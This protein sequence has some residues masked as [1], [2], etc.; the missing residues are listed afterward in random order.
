MT[1]R[2]MALCL[3]IPTSLA[4]CGPAKTP[5]TVEYY[6]QHRTEMTSVLKQ[7]GNNPGQLNADPDCVNASAAAIASQGKGPS[8][9]KY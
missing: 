2:I 8:R 6:M 5:K 7:C 4:G 1:L 9:V 3:L